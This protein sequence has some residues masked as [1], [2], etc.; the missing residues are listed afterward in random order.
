MLR[1]QDELRWLRQLEEESRKLIQVVANLSW[2]EAMLLAVVA[3]NLKG[4]RSFACE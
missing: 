4:L 3:K 1:S 2:D